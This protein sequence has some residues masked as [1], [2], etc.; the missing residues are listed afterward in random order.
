MLSSKGEESRT[1]AAKIK[2]VHNTE[3]TADPVKYSCILS[4]H[5]VWHN[6]SRR[7]DE[8]EQVVRALKKNN[9]WPTEKICS[10]FALF[11]LSLRN[12]VRQAFWVE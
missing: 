7:K 10:V 4:V 8:L 6:S 11:P 9:M 12:P 3:P 2:T 1:K 5:L